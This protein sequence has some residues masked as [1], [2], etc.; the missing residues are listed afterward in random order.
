MKQ[1]GLVFTGPQCGKCNFKLE[2]KNFEVNFCT[3]VY[4]TTRHLCYVSW[5][6]SKLLIQISATLDT[7]TL[8]FCESPLCF[9]LA[10]GGKHLFTAEVLRKHPSGI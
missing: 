7:W 9:P 2:I 6:F 8:L 1:I 10:Q 5:T 4:V 3:P